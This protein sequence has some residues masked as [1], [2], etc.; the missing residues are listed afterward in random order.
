MSIYHICLDIAV[1]MQYGGTA[2]TAIAPGLGLE[3]TSLMNVSYGVPFVEKD[4][5]GEQSGC[6]DHRTAIVVT[7][8]S[9]VSSKIPCIKDV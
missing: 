1:L 9:R 8:G 2:D 3:R 7:F 5:L 6:A 4:T